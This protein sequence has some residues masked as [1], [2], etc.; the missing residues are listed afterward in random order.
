[1]MPIKNLDIPVPRFDRLA[2]AQK[3][4]TP[5]EPPSRTAFWL[6]GLA[7]APHSAL[8]FSIYVISAVDRR[9]AFSCCMAYGS[10]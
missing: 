3:P 1:M 6:L 10:A 5:Q 2:D 9:L 4:A 8:V 7:R